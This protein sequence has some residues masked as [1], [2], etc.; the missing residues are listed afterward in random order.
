M[1]MMIAKGSL[2]AS[3]SERLTLVKN[4]TLKCC[5]RD[6]SRSRP[7]LERRQVTRESLNSSAGEYALGHKNVVAESVQVVHHV[8]HAVPNMCTCL[9]LCAH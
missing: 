6:A 4:I 7:L 5:V 3:N 2:S 9:D 8:Q 1:S